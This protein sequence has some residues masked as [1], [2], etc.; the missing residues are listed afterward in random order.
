VAASAKRPAAWAACACW[1]GVGGAGV[2]G[3][4]EVSFM[5]WAVASAL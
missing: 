4:A 2:W 5:V 3:G 1:K